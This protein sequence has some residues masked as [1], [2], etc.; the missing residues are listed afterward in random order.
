MQER[1]VVSE[2][3]TCTGLRATI[4]RRALPPISCWGKTVDSYRRFCEKLAG[5]PT[6]KGGFPVPEKR[7]NSPWGKGGGER[8][9]KT[10]TTNYWGLIVP[11]F[12]K[13]CL[14]DA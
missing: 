12:E 7:A 3:Q 10:V 5:L 1:L 11:G 6:E 4:S 13:S 14:P 8:R 2:N 9:L